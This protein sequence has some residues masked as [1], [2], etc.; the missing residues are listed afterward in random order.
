MTLSPWSR[1]ATIVFIAFFVAGTGHLTLRSGGGVAAAGC[2]LCSPEGST[3]LLLN[4]GL[5]VPFGFALGLLGWRALAVAA[6]GFAMSA[7]IELL[8]TQIPGRTPSIWDVFT[9]GTG[10]MIGMIIFQRGRSWLA[11]DRWAPWRT[12][13]AALLPP[14]VIWGSGALLAPAAVEGPY[15][16]HLT[17]RTR[18]FDRWSGTL[19]AARIDSVPVTHGRLDRP[20]RTGDEIESGI[21]VAVEGTV[22]RPTGGMAALL[23]V[24]TDATTEAL[25]IGAENED[26]VV[27]VRRRAA[28]L[29]F[30]APDSRFDD[31]L[32]RIPAGDRFVIDVSG[33]PHAICASV[34]GEALCAPRF[35][36]GIL[37]GILYWQ[38]DWR[39]AT[40]RALDALTLLTLLL[41]LGLLVRSVSRTQAIAVTSLCLLAIPIA[42]W[43]QQL[44]WFAVPE[45]GGVAAGLLL[46][47]LA[48]QQLERKWAQST[49]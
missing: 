8:Q 5:F 30:D 18:N 29:L 23:W 6:T 25:L 15:F 11:R 26:L 33:P 21:S 16:A 17:P 24:T 41:P 27:R 40:R 2:L 9:N 46:G 14:V 48:S 20:L 22:G 1:R 49:R 43:S 37:W 19:T 39:P 28:D 45:L 13:A 32:A 44:R 47:V 42:A 7:A 31:A 34:N 38:G 35:S 4:M 36:A 3:D 12:W 10:T